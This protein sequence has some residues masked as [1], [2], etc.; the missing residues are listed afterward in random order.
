MDLY[1]GAG[2]RVD[3]KACKSDS[4]LNIGSDEVLWGGKC[5]AGLKYKINKFVVGVDFSYL[6]TFN[7]KQTSN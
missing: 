1:V 7:K 5:S 4:S 2:P 3:F 6:P